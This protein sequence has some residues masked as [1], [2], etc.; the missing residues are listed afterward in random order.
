[1]RITIRGQEYTLGEIAFTIL[2]ILLAY[3][4]GL[5]INL[6]LYLPATLAAG[7]VLGILVYIWKLDL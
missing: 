3:L 6:Q 4:A 1:M 2:F 5:N 7:E